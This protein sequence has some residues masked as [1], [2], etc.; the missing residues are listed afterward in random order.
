M[1]SRCILCI[2][3]RL[4]FLDKRTFNRNKIDFEKLRWKRTE[5]K[6]K[7][8]MCPLRARAVPVLP[9][10]YRNLQTGVHFWINFQSVA[11]LVVNFALSLYSYHNAK[12]YDFSFKSKSHP[13]NKAT[14]VFFN[15]FF[16]DL[17]NEKK[18]QNIKTL[19]TVGWISMVVSERG[20]NQRVWSVVLHNLE[21]AI[22]LVG[23]SFG[24]ETFNVWNFV[25]IPI[26]RRISFVFW[27]GPLLGV[28]FT[29]KS[30]TN[31]HTFPHSLY[32]AVHTVVNVQ[33]NTSTH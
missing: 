28:F 32:H 18:L 29:V 8:L 31:S 4:I 5:E 15:Y 14:Q 7:P 10:V 23:R 12:S 33:T 26:F 25:F 3:L 30:C 9:P 24:M 17:K 6:I 27:E 2:L 1:A 13:L 21:V 16:G 20:I 22:W 11:S 19:K